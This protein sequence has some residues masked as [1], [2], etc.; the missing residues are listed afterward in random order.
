[1]KLLVRTLY[2][3]VYFFRLCFH[4]CIGCWPCP[5]ILS[6]K[7]CPPLSWAKK[8]SY[9]WPG[10]RTFSLSH[11]HNKQW[12]H[13]GTLHSFFI[14]CSTIT[15]VESSSGSQLYITDQQPSL[16]LWFKTR[17]PKALLRSISVEKQSGWF[18]LSCRTSPPF[19]LS[20]YGTLKTPHS[21]QKPNAMYSVH[22]QKIYYSKLFNY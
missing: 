17:Q 7:V 2:C 11:G 10:L 8:F 3:F 6:Q 5:S 4:E 18:P 19:S 16:F 9:A 22:L 21:T 12:L 20:S 14:F 13:V 15:C 1:M